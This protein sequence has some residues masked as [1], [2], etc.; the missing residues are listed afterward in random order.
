MYKSYKKPKKK[1]VETV[2]FLRKQREGEREQIPKTEKRGK[3][4][5]E[6]K[7]A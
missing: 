6:H 2:D 7:V 1:K 4:N 5:Q 3:E